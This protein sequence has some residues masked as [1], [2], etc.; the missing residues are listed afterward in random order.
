MILVDADGRYYG[1]DAAL[2][3]AR[4]REGPAGEYFDLGPAEVAAARLPETAHA[5]LQTAFTYERAGGLDHPNSGAE[6]RLSG[7][8]G[9]AS[10]RMVGH[11]G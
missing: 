9:D 11:I 3:E 10:F 2:L 4:R 7:Q 5:A 6:V 8:P 1:F